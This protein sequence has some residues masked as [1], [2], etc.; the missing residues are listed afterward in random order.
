MILNTI[1]VYVCVTLVTG[2]GSNRGFLRTL[3]L[4]IMKQA[5][6]TDANIG[7]HYTIFAP[8]HVQSFASSLIVEPVPLLIN[9]Q[10]MKFRGT[11]S[12]PRIWQFALWIHYY[13]S[14]QRRQRISFVHVSNGCE[15]FIRNFKW[16]MHARHISSF[17]FADS[18]PQ[19]IQIACLCV[20]FNDNGVIL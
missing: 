5:L 4:C 10:W 9:K 1:V 13:L 7:C 3:T 16:P 12:R 15:Y 19:N 11:L 17:S 2:I 18:Q 6:C 8:C 14:Q 20:E